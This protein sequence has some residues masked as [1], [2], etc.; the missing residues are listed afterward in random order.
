VHF[1][2]STMIAMKMGYISVFVVEQ[3]YLILKTKF[4]SGTGWPSFWKPIAD[5]NVKEHQDRS[6]GMIRIEALCARCDAHLGHVFN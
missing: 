2:E 6:Y 1:Q 5:E 4:E 3:I